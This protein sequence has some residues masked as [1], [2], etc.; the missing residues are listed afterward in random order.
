MMREQLHEQISAFLDGELPKPEVGLLLRRLERE[1][2]LKLVA[3]RYA[4]IGESLRRGASTGLSPQFASKIS[5]AISRE[6]PHSGRGRLTASTGGEG[7]WR[8]V[9]G[10]MG[11]MAVAATVAG[12]AL[13]GLQRQ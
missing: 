3:T 1:P 4:A 8:T 10:W 12:I 2:E 11:G 5:G 6:G 9:A 13:L 7:R